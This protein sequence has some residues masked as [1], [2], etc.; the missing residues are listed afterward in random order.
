MD[1][2][3]KNN[4]PAKPTWQQRLE[5]ETCFTTA[6]RETAWDLL[7]T[8]LRPGRQRPATWYSV[9]AAC[10]V[11][12][13]VYPLTIVMHR[14]SSPVETVAQKN[15]S[16][17]IVMSTQSIAMP[18]TISG[19][20][21]YQ[22]VPSSKPALQKKLPAIGPTKK[23]TWMMADSLQAG[24]GIVLPE[25]LPTPANTIAATIGKPAVT[26]KLRVVHQNELDAPVNGFNNNRTALNYSLIQIGYGNGPGT[27]AKPATTS[28]I[29][30]SISTAKNN[31]SN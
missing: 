11:F 22:A 20:Q 8:R 6:G 14:N 16:A 7:Q 18:V 12:L 1:T 28:S 29:G 3:L 23:I 27:I 17:P 13:L 31:D 21:Q 25:T 15:E 24:T 10:L 2:E 9:A 4:D 30:W 5:A 26:K 19:A